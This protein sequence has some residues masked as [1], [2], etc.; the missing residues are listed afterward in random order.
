M[1]L[2]RL[3]RITF[4][5]FVAFMF[6][7]MI[8][9]GV[10]KVNILFHVSLAL[11]LITIMMVKSARERFIHD[12]EFLPAL[13]LLT[14]FVL[15][16]SISNLWAET[17]HL[18]SALTHSFYILIF[19][20]LY[21][22]CE[23][24]NKKTYLVGATYFGIIV[25]TLM[26]FIYVNKPHLFVG[27]LMNA[28]PYAPDN[29]ID[30][31]GYMALGIILST[32]L[33]RE[34]RSLWY[35]APV[36]LLLSGLL[37]TQ[38]RGPLLALMIA[39]AVVFCIKP[40]WNNK[41]VFLSLATL[42]I[43]GITL[44]YSGFY[45]LL[46]KRFE[47]SNQ[48]GSVRF[49]IW[50]HAFEVTKERLVFGWGFNKELSFINGYKQHVTTTHSLYFSAFLKG[51]IVGLTLFLAMIAYAFRQC[52]R[53]LAVDHKAEVAVLIFALVF[54]STQGMFVISNPR[55]YWVLFW[56]P[57]AIIFSTPVKKTVQR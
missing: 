5:P 50:Q 42:L 30:L 41:I 16:F 27:R 38:S 24:E 29:V 39:T 12:K 20:C 9:C 51:G 54:Y 48:A 34:T 8:F 10:S 28:F 11:F 23:L 49:G 14:L 53:H 36:P 6:L 52:L 57:L 3:P 37:L 40:K 44:Y 25:L 55:E 45:D 26:T 46:I 7:S 15:Y 32:I 2:N 35:Y 17:S 47:D 18:S 21:R 33:V 22:Q 19:F 13:G 43:L 4:Y 56:I 31:G 1:Y